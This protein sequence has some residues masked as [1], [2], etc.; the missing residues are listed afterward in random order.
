MCYSL[1]KKI[2]YPNARNPLEAFFSFSNIPPGNRDKFW[3][4][5]I[6]Q[7][8]TVSLY[9]TAES[10]IKQRITNWERL[11]HASAWEIDQNFSSSLSSLV[12]FF[13]RKPY[14]QQNW[15]EW[16]IFRAP[17]QRPSQNFQ[18][19]KSLRRSEP[20][21]YSFFSFLVPA[22]TIYTRNFGAYSHP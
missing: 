9:Y 14:M 11:F 20:F 2:K 7:R 15:D 5:A 16:S 22:L 8:W 1:H 4:R 3:Y 19:P 6:D 18:V 21:Y 10:L 12:I 17:I 13:S